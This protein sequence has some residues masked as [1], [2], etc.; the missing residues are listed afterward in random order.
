MLEWTGDRL[1]HC[2]GDRNCHFG[3]GGTLLQ[4]CPV[5]GPCRGAVVGDCNM[6]SY[7]ELWHISRQPLWSPAASCFAGIALASTLSRPCHRAGMIGRELHLD[8]PGGGK[9]AGRWRQDN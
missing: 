7:N 6:L 5:A 1:C 2:A 8:L 9:E 3:I 4:D